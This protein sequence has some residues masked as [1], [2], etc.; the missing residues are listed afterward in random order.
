MIER[1]IYTTEVDDEVVEAY[2]WEESREPG[3]RE[4]FL[5]CS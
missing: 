3:L 2:D 1:V 5:G 4:D